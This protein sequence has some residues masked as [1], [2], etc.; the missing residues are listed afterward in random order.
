MNRRVLK[1]I[2]H[3]HSSHK[4]ETTTSVLQSVLAVDQPQDFPFILFQT[5]IR[6][7]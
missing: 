7:S 6:L 2:L 5:L 1:M 3:F 4:H